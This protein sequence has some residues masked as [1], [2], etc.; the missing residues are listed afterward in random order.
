MALTRT[1][2]RKAYFF[3]LKYGCPAAVLAITWYFHW[4]PL[5]FVCGVLMLFVPGRILGYFWRDQLR[6]LRLLKAKQY[7]ESLRHSQ[8][9]LDTLKCHSWIRHL[10]WLGSGTYSRSPE[11]FA[12]NN[13]GAA[14]IALGRFDL[15][16]VHLHEAIRHDNLNPMPF[17]NLSLLAKK[18]GNAEEATHMLKAAVQRGLTFGATDKIV[19]SS[20]KRFAH[21]DGKGTRPTA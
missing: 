2:Y 18:E 21:N 7:E 11:A 16:R 15:A 19:M 12:Y 4:N 9:F 14:E 17:Y 5:V 6:G 20:Q 3:T 1:A 13:I 10:I 8:A